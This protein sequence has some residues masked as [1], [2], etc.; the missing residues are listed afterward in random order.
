MTINAG[1]PS[2]REHEYKI[3]R[4]FLAHK[5]HAQIRPG[6]DQANFVADPFGDQRRLGVVDGDALFAVIPALVLI[7]FRDNGVAAHRENLV[8]ESAFF[9]VEDLTLPTE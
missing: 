2:L 5:Y 6:C 4:F 7:D 9:L 3:D 8:H 1:W